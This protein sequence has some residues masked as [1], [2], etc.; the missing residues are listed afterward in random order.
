MWFWWLMKYM[1]SAYVQER[2]LLS[3]QQAGGDVEIDAIIGDIAD[4]K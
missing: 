2:A 1:V 3:W 4:C